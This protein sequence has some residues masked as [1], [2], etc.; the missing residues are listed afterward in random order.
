M[1]LR[2]SEGTVLVACPDARP[3]AFQAVIGL[4][5]A[6][7]LRGFL[8]ACYYDP[9]SRLASFARR[10]V[11][12]RFS[13]IERI[14]LRRHDPEIPKSAVQSVPFFDLLLRLEARFG[15]SRP[16]VTRALARWR[17]KHFDLQLARTIERSRPDVLL[18]FSDVGSMA[19]LP[20]CRRLGIKSIVS[21]VHGDVREEHGVLA[22]ETATSA[23]FMR[24]YLGNGA[25]DLELLAWLHERRLCDLAL[26]DRVLVPSWHIAE[27]LVRQGTPEGKVRV[28]PYAADCRRFRP[29]AGKRHGPECTFLFAGG[30]SGRKGIKYL[31]E[32]WRRIRRPSWRLE[33][34]GPLP[35]DLG[36]LEPY[37]DFI[38]PLGRVSHAEMPARLAAADVFVFPSLFEGSAVVTYEALACGLPSIVT[39]NAGS[40]VRDGIEG[41]LV[42]CSEVDSLA[43]RMEQ[44]GN[45]PGLRAT[46]GLAARARAMAFDWPRYHDALIAAVDELMRDGPTT[47]RVPANRREGT[48]DSSYSNSQS[49]PY[50]S[51][52]R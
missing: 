45:D 33:L 39:P 4:H 16:G 21:M 51:P 31:L 42:P 30:I 43:Q 6:G 50:C 13:R 11:P 20:L 5:Q 28:V 41:F 37:L 1:E 35:A 9:G 7:R 44:L 48:D 25:L 3:P 52:V 34:L 40:V 27:T 8:T 10:L 15:A 12:G 17:T 46:M 2:Q 36:P 18:A 26:A 29:L 23:D 49:D 24:I 38:E 47:S 32:A 14:L 19:A 22:R